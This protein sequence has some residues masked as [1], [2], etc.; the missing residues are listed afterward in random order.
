ME[1][2]SI[3]DLGI[4]KGQW[5]V[6]VIRDGKDGPVVISRQTVPNTI[7]NVGKK[8]IFRMA[9]SLSTKAFKYMKLGTS[10]AAIVSTQ[11][12]AQ[13]VLASSLKL[14]DTYTMSGRTFQLIFS[15]HTGSTGLSATLKEMAIWN[16][17]TS[18]GGSAFS[19]A[20]LTSPIPKTKSDKVKLT[21][22]ARLT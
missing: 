17:A 4:T 22:T 15:Y 19:R 10:S 20:L 14:V 5:T 18:A 8:Q 11:T 21:Y 3:N 1:N 6:E 13:A 7:L 12:N 9:S 16:T 2:N